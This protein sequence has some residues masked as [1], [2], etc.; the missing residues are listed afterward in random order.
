MVIKEYGQNANRRIV[1]SVEMEVTMERGNLFN[2][3]KVIK[4]HHY[5]MFCDSE[6]DFVITN[7]MVSPRAEYPMCKKCAELFKC[8]INIGL[9]MK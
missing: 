3:M 6:A 9:E 7:S 8:S 4:G 2:Q 5:C 1:L